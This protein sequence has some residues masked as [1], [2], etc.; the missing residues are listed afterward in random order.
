M[1]SYYDIIGDVVFHMFML[2]IVRLWEF[3]ASLKSFVHNFQDFISKFDPV[4]FNRNEFVP[5][6]LNFLR[7]QASAV[8][9][10]NKTSFCSPLKPFAPVLAQKSASSSYVPHLNSSSS[11]SCRSSLHHFS[12]LLYETPSNQKWTFQY[13]SFDSPET[14]CAILFSGR[15]DI[16][17]QRSSLGDFVS[18]TD[19]SK[20]G[21]KTRNDEI[22]PSVG[23]KRN[24]T[25]GNRI[26]NSGSKIRSRIGEQ[27]ESPSVF[28][29]SSLDDFPDVTR[30]KGTPK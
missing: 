29:L 10:D 16:R 22:S 21:R 17:G 30:L 20:W 25:R 2:E 26:F 19:D 9:C 8:L 5:F 15:R 27:M 14:E 12:P 7:D 1:L 18:T 3:L 28:D 13:A 11:K 23:G 4:K 6:F 24:N